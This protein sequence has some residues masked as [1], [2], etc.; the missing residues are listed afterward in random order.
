MIW[1]A[2]TIEKFIVI[3]STIGRRPS[4]AMPTAVPIIPASAIGVSTTLFGPY[5]LSMPAVIRNVPS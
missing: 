5:F 3:I 1:S 4:M 2:A